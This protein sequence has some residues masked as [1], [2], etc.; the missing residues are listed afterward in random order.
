MHAYRRSGWLAAT[1]R[2]KG[3]SKDRGTSKCSYSTE[4]AVCGT[5]IIEAPLAV[6]SDDM[7][8]CRVVVPQCGAPDNRHN[9]PFDMLVANID[10]RLPRHGRTPRHGTGAGEARSRAEWAPVAPQPT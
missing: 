3:S 9:Y 8:H 10:V 6:G 4:G 7:K 2:A 1:T 5:S